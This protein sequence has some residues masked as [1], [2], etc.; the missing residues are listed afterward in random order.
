M[1]TYSRVQNGIDP[2]TIKSFYKPICNFTN[3]FGLNFVVNSYKETLKEP[4]VPKPFM[5][6]GTSK[7]EQGTYSCTFNYSYALLFSKFGDNNYVICIGS[8][9]L[10]KFRNFVQAMI[11][12]MYNAKFTQEANRIFV[13]GKH[14]GTEIISKRE[15]K[16]SINAIYSYNDQPSRGA[17]IYIDG[18]HTCSITE[19]NLCELYEFM[20]SDLNNLSFN[21]IQMASMA[22][23]LAYTTDYRQPQGKITNAADTKSVS[24]LRTGRLS[25]GSSGR[26]P[27]SSTTTLSDL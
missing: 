19:W 5:V 26:K 9:E 7:A 4:Y 8:G 17:D 3:G 11:K 16:Y 20:R 24:E 13:I 27:K 14:E 12:A 6:L 1:V 15:F 25:V 10:Y 21:M 22:T 23:Y 2:T 18:I